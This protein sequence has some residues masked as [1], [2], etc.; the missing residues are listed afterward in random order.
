MMRAAITHKRDRLSPP[1]PGDTKARL[2]WVIYAGVALALVGAI[3]LMFLPG[4]S[5]GLIGVLGIGIVLL[6]IFLGVPVAIALF[7]GGILGI[8]RLAGIA[9]VPAIMREAPYVA[10]ANWTLSVLPMFIFMGLVM[11]RSGISERVFETARIWVG[12]LPGGLAAATNL[13]G[14]GLASASGSSLGISYAL[15]RIAIPEMLRLGYKPSLASAVVVVA[16]TLGQLIP[17]SIILVIY[18]GVASTPVGPQLLAAVVPGILLAIAYTVMILIRSHLSPD[19]APRASQERLP[20]R[21]KVRSLRHTLPVLAIVL[22]VLGTMFGGIA[23]AT[24]AGAFGAFLAVVFT[25]ALNRKDALKMIGRALTDS[26]SAVAAILF[27]IVGI[28]VL[29]RMIS[30]SGIAQ[31]VADGVGSLG[32]GRI[33]FL[34]LLMLVFL[35]LGTV[36]DP[37]ALI[38]LTVPV[39][40]PTLARMDVNPIWFGVFLVMLAELAVVT[41]PV[42]INA[43]IVHRLAQ[44]PAVNLGHK[45]TLGD[46]FG[47]SLWFV[48]VSLL[49]ATALIFL[50]DLALWLPSVSLS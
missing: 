34:L 13:A 33:V 50:P 46:V 38:L 19:L 16:G 21:E 3:A 43:Y 22:V 12:G 40:G 11:W 45:V 28:G 2:P 4:A 32:L 20:W 47:G 29:N 23:T 24:E 25:F 39:L 18:S 49:L 9:T 10:A 30:L 44:D 48:F 27:L 15:G 8:W 42:G 41:P 31:A 7:F 6:L 37:M 5:R 1:V 36:M 14:A 17:P 26:V 35:L